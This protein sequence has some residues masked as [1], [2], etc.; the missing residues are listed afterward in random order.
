MLRPTGGEAMVRRDGDE[1][2]AWGKRELDHFEQRLVEERRRALAEM[3]RLNDTIGAS[4]DA[5]SGELTTWRFHMA[6]VG[7]ETF[8]REQNNLMASREGQLLWHINEGLRRLYGSPESFGRCE[9]CGERIAYE[10]LDA[11]PYVT[12]CVACKQDWEGAGGR[13]AR[14]AA[15]AGA[16]RPERDEAND[17]A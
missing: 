8:E 17:A 7:T 12:R 11:I 1:K 10:R 2:S 9:E 6:D 3:G 13:G 5:Q 4:E 15:D 14:G 16:A